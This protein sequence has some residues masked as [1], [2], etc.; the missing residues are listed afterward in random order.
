MIRPPDEKATERLATCPD[1][2]RPLGATALDSRPPLPA[3]LQFLRVARLAKLSL[4]G[5]R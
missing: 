5:K 4:S 3:G 1:C 2:G